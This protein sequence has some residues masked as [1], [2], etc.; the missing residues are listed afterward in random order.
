MSCDL[1]ELGVGTRVT[2]DSGCVAEVITPT[3]DGEWILVKYVSAPNAP[4]LVGTDD[5]CNVKEVVSSS[6]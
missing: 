6:P 4:N 2:L 3:V 1:W 5:L